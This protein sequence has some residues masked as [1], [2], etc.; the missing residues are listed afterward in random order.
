VV[1]KFAVGSL[2]L[3][4]NA[5]KLNTRHQT[6]EHQ[7]PKHQAPNSIPNFNLRKSPG[8]KNLYSGTEI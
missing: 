5:K 1:R 8:G 4:A 2:K 6:P 3:A 7:I